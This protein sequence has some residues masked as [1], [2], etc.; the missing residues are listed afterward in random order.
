MLEEA[1]E[2]HEIAIQSGI[3]LLRA[4]QSDSEEYF[5]VGSEKIEQIIKG[6]ESESPE[7]HDEAYETLRGLMK[8]LEGDPSET[9]QIGYDICAGLAS[10]LESGISLVSEKAYKVADEANKQFAGYYQIAS[11]SRL[12]KRQGGF[13]TEGLAIGLEKGLN[14]PLSAMSNM[15]DK[16]H[17]A[18]DGAFDTNTYLMPAV[19]A[20]MS[21]IGYRTASSYDMNSYTNTTDYESIGKEVAKAIGDSGIK[22]EVGR[23]EFGRLVNEVI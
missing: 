5:G 12:M 4:C 15:S 14:S 10:G 1:K 19:S 13:I 2:Q 11:P 20:L 9:A 22:V 16:L 3:D 21:G 7:L 6:L 23:R 18:F 17:H 8:N